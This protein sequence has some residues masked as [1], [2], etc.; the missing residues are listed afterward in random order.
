MVVQRV[1]AWLILYSIRLHLVV[2]D[3]IVVNRTVLIGDSQ[4]VK[5]A[6]EYGQSAAYLLASVANDTS[7]APQI[8]ITLNICSQPWTLRNSTNG[9]SLRDPLLNPPKMSMTLWQDTNSTRLNTTQALQAQDTRWGFGNLTYSGNATGLKLVVTAPDHDDAWEKAVAFHYS[10]AMTSDAPLHHSYSGAQN[11]FLFLQDS[12]YEAA[13][14]TTGNLTSSVLPAHGIFINP[15][16][17]SRSNIEE[18]SAIQNALQWSWCGITSTPSKYTIANADRSL[19][20]RGPGGLPKEQFYVHGL[21]PGTL[22]DAYV[23][24]QDNSSLGG[25]VWPVAQF[26]TR[27][28]QDCQIVYD[29]PF[30]DQV[31]YTVP[32]NRTTHSAQ[33]LAEWYDTNARQ[34]Y[35]NFSKTMQVYDCNATI[36]STF[37][38][39]TNCDACKDAYKDWLCTTTIP[40]CADL[41]DDAPHLR[42][43]APPSTADAEDLEKLAIV[44][45]STSPLSKQYPLSG[46]TTYGSRFGLIDAVIQP[47]AYREVLPCSDLAE[48]VAAKCPAGAL[49]VRVP[50]GQAFWDL[51]YGQRSQNGTVTCNAPGVDFW[52]AAA[53]RSAHWQS[54]ATLSALVLMTTLLIL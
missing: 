26:R 45:D 31:A 40:R 32:S 35:T 5:D 24:L 34:L 17:G 37:S 23:T 20:T 8:Y 41:A 14:L 51:A 15:A 11:R 22:Y 3:T 19:T 21:K 12:D 42:L 48:K 9:T 46:L 38:L 25:A 50:F 4:L 6:L 54:L 33:Q 29:L 13:L 36:G 43:R 44:L 47:G 10:L 1:L 39:A 53:G 27:Q 7:E 28:K 49:D 16:S 2:A 52:V 18:A 30:C